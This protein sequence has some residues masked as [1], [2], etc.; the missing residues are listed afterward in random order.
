MLALCF[1]ALLQTPGLHC[2]A[3]LPGGVCLCLCPFPT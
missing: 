3:L 2:L 1:L